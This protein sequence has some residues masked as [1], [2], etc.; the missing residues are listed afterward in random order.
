MARKNPFKYIS[1]YTSAI[2]T[3]LATASSAA[4]LPLNLEASYRAGIDKNIANFVLPLGSTLN[5]NGSSI[6]YPVTILFI[7]FLY[8]KPVAFG[9]QILLSL[10]TV[11]V[12]VGSAPV[13]SGALVYLTLVSET[14]GVTLPLQAQSL[15]WAIDPIMDRILT[16]TNVLGDSF[17]VALIEVT[18]KW[19]IKRRAKK[20]GKNASDEFKK[21]ATQVNISGEDDSGKPSDGKHPRERSS[22]ALSRTLRRMR[23]S[24]QII[25]ESK[26]KSV[27]KPLREF[28]EKMELSPKSDDDKTAVKTVFDVPVDAQADV[29]DLP[30][31]KD[32]GA[33]SDNKD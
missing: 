20:D 10:V 21:I 29:G 31:N 8:K 2:L 16:A 12:T 4:A 22:S 13:P 1:H 23:R 26:R 25:E 27:T 9:T 24:Q 17:S 3:A 5:M 33:R 15:I 18:F 14:V 19:M 32:D 28:E 6:Y 11:F 30:G 7:G